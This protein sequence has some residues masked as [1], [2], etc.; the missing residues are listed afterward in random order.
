MDGLV[1]EEEFVASEEDEITHPVP[2][3]VTKLQG[4]D[5]MSAKKFICDV[6][7]KGLSTKSS[8][9]VHNRIHTGERPFACTFCSKSFQTSN[10]LAVHKRIHTGERPY[11]CSQC[12]MSFKISNQLKRHRV[13]HIQRP[14]IRCQ[15]CGKDVDFKKPKDQRAQDL[16]EG[17]KQH[18][19][20]PRISH[21]CG[22]CSKTFSGVSALTRHWQRTHS[23]KSFQCVT[24]GRAYN[25]NSAL[26]I[27]QRI[28]TG[29]Q[30]VCEVCGKRFQQNSHLTV[31]R[32]AHSGE[33]PFQCK[34]CPRGFKQS[35]HLKDHQR[36][37]TGERPFVCQCGKSFR[38]SGQHRDHQRF[39]CSFKKILEVSD[40]SPV[41]T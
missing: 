5:E 7:G 10:G 23:K 19:R 6:C 17:G 38:Q 22:K 37:H 21:A 31:H 9:K 39:Y 3:A 29:E 30:F 18:Q 20:P 8:L 41:E 24:C 16:C 25:Q 34:Y 11:H 36:L 4:D 15:R 35:S 12:P 2:S 28:H 14:L 13:T 33:L 1:I 27:H 26:M 40:L 32:R